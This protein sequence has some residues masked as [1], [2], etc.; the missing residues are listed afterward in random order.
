MSKAD[1]DNNTTQSKHFDS[2][3]AEVS[4]G[5]FDL[6]EDILR[7]RGLA[8]AIQ[9]LA[10]SDEM[11]KEPGAALNSVADTLVIGLNYLI[12]ERERLWRLAH[13]AIQPSTGTA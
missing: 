2:T 4:S 12:T 7:S 10:T 13:G 11:P 9:M 8:Y 3:I 1:T 5:L 6:E